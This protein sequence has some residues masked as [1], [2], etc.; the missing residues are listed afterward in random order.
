[1]TRT[2]HG[3][4]RGDLVVVVDCA[5][6]ERASRFWAG[7]LG[8]VGEGGADGASYRSLL[9]P[10][11]VGAEIL[12]QRTE[13]AKRG[14]NRMHLDLRTR[15]L[16][17]EVSRITALGA[18]V[19]TSAPIVEHGWAW[20]VLADPDGNEFCILQPPADYW[21]DSSRELPGC[22]FDSRPDDVGSGGRALLVD[23]QPCHGAPDVAAS[24]QSDGRHA[25]E[26]RRR[27][28]RQRSARWSA[29]ICRTTLRPGIPVTPPPPCVPDPAW[30]S[31]RTGVRRSA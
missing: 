5:D 18:I 6:L 27:R 12:L 23:R 19:L 31:P 8:Y 21:A 9:P 15:D 2:Q 20:H 29:R 11:G 3:Y 28:R 10:G 30:Y 26:P 14:K 22:G 25:T 7:A 13:D 17:A 24:D 16:D 1:M 4:A